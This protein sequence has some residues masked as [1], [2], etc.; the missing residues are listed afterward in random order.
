MAEKKVVYVD[1]REE[2]SGIPAIL[3]KAGLVV[4]R[5]QLPMG[6]YLI[7]DTI[8]VERKTAYDFAR[9]LFDGRLFEQ[10][11]RLSE[12]Y[13]VVVYI[14][15]GNP[16]R[17]RR[18]RTRLK[19]LT[20]ALVTLSIDYGARTLFSEGPLH[21]AS[22]IESLAARL[23]SG[24][25]G[26]II[27][28]KPKIEDTRAWQLYVLQSFPGIGPKT[29]ERILERFGSLQ[30]FFNASMAELSKI[31][32]IG[33][34]KAETIRRIITYGGRP[35]PRAKLSLEDFVGENED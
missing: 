7:S 4:V 23:E 1:I 8:I 34:K 19:Q 12:S 17:L 2:K 14:I 29:A 28:K 35:R 22:I 11:R 6:D 33:E 27:H 26:I 20:A 25:R 9:S 18:Y 21:T 24:R 32:G 16:Y 13:P 15:E 10:A 3:E 30:G 5:K 31:P